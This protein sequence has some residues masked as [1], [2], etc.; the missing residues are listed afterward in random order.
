[1]QVRSALRSLRPEASMERNET[2]QTDTS[3]KKRVRFNRGKMV[4]LTHHRTG[5]D[6]SRLTQI[7]FAFLLHTDHHSKLIQPMILSAPSTG[8][9]VLLVLVYQCHILQS[10]L[11]L[12]S[13]NSED[14]SMHVLAQ[15]CG[16][17]TS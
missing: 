9:S 11:L 6:G 17:G 2:K 4:L 14:L 12:Y 1:M 10:G 15:G 8:I 7:F 3:P 16:A 13:I 5:S